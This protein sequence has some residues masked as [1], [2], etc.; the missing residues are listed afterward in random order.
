LRQCRIPIN[1]TL[2]ETLTNFSV[3]KCLKLIGINWGYAADNMIKMKLDTGDLLFIKYDCNQTFGVDQY[4][5]CFYNQ[6]FAGDTYDDIG[7]TQRKEDEVFIWKTD[8]G[9]NF[10]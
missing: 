4:V 8:Q 1:S 6:L 7:W 3:T 10:H 2:R 9:C 5:H